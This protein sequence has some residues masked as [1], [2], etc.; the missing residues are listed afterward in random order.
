MLAVSQ[1]VS[2][3]HFTFKG[4]CSAL[5]HF[6]H[7]ITLIFTSI[8]FPMAFSPCRSNMEVLSGPWADLAVLL[9]QTVTQVDRE[10]DS[11]L[12]LWLFGFLLFL[13]VCL[14]LLQLIIYLSWKLRQVEAELAEFSQDRSAIYRQT[15]RQAHLRRNAGSHSHT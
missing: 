1:H 12:L 13:S 8:F 6:N 2:W 7:I 9:Q 11:F 10:A 14:V 15:D 4:H 5:V 3:T